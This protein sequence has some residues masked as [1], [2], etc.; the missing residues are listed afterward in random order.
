M[1]K[2]YDTDLQDNRLWMSQQFF[3]DQDVK[4]RQRRVRREG[5]STRYERKARAEARLKAEEIEILAQGLK[6]FK[7]K[8]ETEK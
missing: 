6:D 2:A 4:E 8:N 1:R 7:L 5:H 3:S